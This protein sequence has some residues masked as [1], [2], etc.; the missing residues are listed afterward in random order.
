MTNSSNS[1]GYNDG[2]LRIFFVMHIR[3][4][5]SVMLELAPC[6]DKWFM[7]ACVKYQK[8]KN[9]LGQNC[10]DCDC[11][12]GFWGINCIILGREGISHFSFREIIPLSDD[13]A[14]LVLTCLSNCVGRTGGLNFLRISFFNL[15]KWLL[16]IPAHVKYVMQILL[17]YR[18]SPCNCAELFVW[19]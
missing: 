14:S 2:A 11:S 5:N 12:F 8:I 7:L 4:L 13:L 3:T 17:N 19:V 18:S 6:A 15:I 1:S 16:P 9:L 10:W